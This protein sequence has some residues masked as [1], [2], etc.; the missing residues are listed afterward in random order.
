MSDKRQQDRVERRRRI[1]EAA[2][3]LF[4]R[5]GFHRTSTRQ[6]ARR[7]GVAEGTI[8]NHFPT[9]KDLLVAA[10]AQ[11]VDEYL[12]EDLEASPRAGTLELLRET[13]HS[14]LELGWR[15]AD[16]IRFLLGE[17]LMNREMRQAYFEA[18]VLRL[19]DRLVGLLEQRVAQG[20]VRPCNV[21]VVAGALVGA[22]LT[23]LLVALLDEER[24]LLSDPLEE[25][26]DEL[27]RLFLYGLQ[28]QAALPD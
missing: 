4:A 10:A 13:F 25:I 15:H 11:V 18:V 27:A 20:Y 19:T 28:P 23:F 7:A 3:D 5:Q 24:R 26:S 16:R 2:L 9:K 17:L 1:L 22:F 8:F 6:I 21:R 14:R 12:G